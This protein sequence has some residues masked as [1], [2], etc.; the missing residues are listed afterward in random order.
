M[1]APSLLFS[2]KVDG[3]LLFMEGHH[4]QVWEDGS[5]KTAAWIISVL[6]VLVFSL[7]GYGWAQA[8]VPISPG[9]ADGKG[10]VISGCPTFSWAEVT[11]A[12]GYKL[13]V[14]AYDA[15]ELLPFY[16]DIATVQTPVLEYDI[17]VRA[18]SWTPSADLGLCAGTYVWYVAAVQW[19][20]V[21]EWSEGRVFRVDAL[22]GINAATGQCIGAP[23]KMVGAED[24][25]TS[26]EDATA[27]G[28]NENP[29]YSLE[30]VLSKEVATEYYYKL[31]DNDQNRGGT[32]ARGPI[33]R[34]TEGISN[35]FYGQ[36]AGSS[37]DGNRSATFI[38]V[39]AGNANTTGS[40]NTFVGRYAGEANT[41]GSDNTFIGTHAG[42][43]NTT[44]YDNLF[45][46]RS[47]GSANTTGNRNTIVGRYSGY[48]NTTGY[49]NTFLGFAA[50][51]FNLEGRSN[52]N[53]GYYSG[54]SNTTGDYNTTLG[55]AAGYNNETGS[56]N[57]F[58]GYQAGYNE[59]GSN[60]LYIDNSNTDTPLVYGEFDNNLVKIHGELQMT[61]AAGPSDERLKKKYQAVAVF[62]K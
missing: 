3:V 31:T 28:V 24:I 55:R 59:T 33:L 35:T 44:G 21:L 5:M 20:E 49:Y 30:Q 53:I 26:K 29:A 14:F 37:I 22:A 6:G 39:N 23:S 36:G 11:E 7:A 62:T 10:L 16:E 46:G 32:S 50:G 41:T 12:T 45:M 27:E 18:L 52:T 25:R 60:K 9:T 8:P 61:A 34:G 48:Y 38:G 56:A 51:F 15:A 4:I 1:N 57:V 43:N 13:K 54:Y 2:G 58:I 17:P 19:G 42:Y 40:S 47:A